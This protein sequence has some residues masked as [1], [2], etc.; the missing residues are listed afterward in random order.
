MRPPLN[1]HRGLY[2]S[3]EFF[4][5]AKW[6]PQECINQVYIIRNWC[7]LFEVGN[8]SVFWPRHAALLHG[9]PEA[10]SPS[11]HPQALGRSVLVNSFFMSH[12]SYDMAYILSSLSMLVV[13]RVRSELHVLIAEGYVFPSNAF[14]AHRT[15][16]A[17]TDAW[18]GFYHSFTPQ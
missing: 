11:F 3:S 4:L 2:N 15:K 7:T 5:G 6:V 14:V 13:R 1:R 17:S 16:V 12:A 18:C 8:V 10:T 9:G